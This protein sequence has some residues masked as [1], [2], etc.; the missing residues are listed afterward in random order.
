MNLFLYLTIVLIWGS[1]W[2]A[3]KFQ[4][5]VVAP[6]L[7]IC[8]RFALAAVL[9]ALWCRCRGIP[10]RLT[11]QQ[12]ARLALLGLLL[13]SVNYGAVYEAERHLP[14]GLVALVFAL[15]PLFNLLNG[16][17]LLGRPVQPQVLLGAVVGLGGMVV[18]FWPDILGFDISSSGSIGLAVAL[19]GTVFASLGNIVAI[20]NHELQIPVMAGTTIAMAYGALFMGL[21]V[22]VT[23]QPLVIDWS[24]PY[25]LSLLYLAVMGSVLAF[26]IYLTLLGRIGP[27]RVAYSALLVPIVALAGSTLVEGYVWGWRLTVGLVLILIGNVI[28]LGPKRL[29]VA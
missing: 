6:S 17:L 8:L 7:S 5:G 25:L 2:L 14:S 26:S 1:T 4:L 10:L 28:V 12:H 3:I 16:G 13:F 20:K 27:E 11:L 21:W 29:R 23:G 18:T 22:L 19:A 24:A 15:L 9:M